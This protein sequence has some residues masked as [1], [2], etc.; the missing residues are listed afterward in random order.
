M[1]KLLP[2]IQSVTIEQLSN[3]TNICGP[4]EIR[5]PNLLVANE[6]RYRYAMGPNGSGWIC[7]IIFTR[8]SAKGGLIST[9]LACGSL[10]AESKKS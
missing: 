10:S 1:V 3:P 5:T 8:C 2:T 9:K 7:R 6:A 4:K